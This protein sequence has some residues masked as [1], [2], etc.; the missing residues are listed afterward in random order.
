MRVL[1]LSVTTLALVATALLSVRFW[2][3]SLPIETFDHPWFHR[4]TPW[5]IV[6]EGLATQAD[7]QATLWIEVIR[8]EEQNLYAVPQNFDF[9]RKKWADAELVGKA[10]PLVEDLRAWGN[11]DLILNIRSN[12]ENIDLQIS[13]LIGKSGNGRL[14]IQSD[15][16]LVLQ[17]IKKLQPLWLFGTS[18][19]E[20][21]RLRS[22]E[23]MGILPAA[24]IKA[25]VYIGPFKQRGVE[26]LTEQVFAEMKRRGKKIIVGP[27]ETP[28][29][30]ELALRRGADGL[31]VNQP[32]LLAPAGSH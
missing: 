5:L 29:E 12:V 22:F 24:P 27:I 25:D 3:L 20:R 2:G 30:R 1:L 8:S 23:S 15:Y 9:T 32:E 7:P 11:R 17:S 21:V 16:D 19:A 26:L 14:L 4:P 31:Y 6:P 28:E 10:T 13:D 18:Q